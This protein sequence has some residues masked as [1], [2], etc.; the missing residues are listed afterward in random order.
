MTT[1][2]AGDVVQ[3]V[4]RDHKHFILQLTPGQQLHTHRGIFEHD[5]LIGRTL[6][7]EVFTHRGDPFFLLQP[8][9]DD[10]IREIKRNSQIIYP[11]DI[12]FILMKLSVRPGVTVVEAGTGSGGL[13]TVLAQAVG[14]TGRVISYEVREDMQNLARKNLERVG[15]ADRITFKLRDIAEGFDETDVYAL[16]LDVPNPWDYTGQ[17]YR[18]LQSGGF[19]GS[20]VP[21][22]NQVS[23]LLVSMR[24]EGFDFVEVCEVLLRYY[25]PVPDRLRPTDRMVA[26]T[27]FLIFGRPVIRSTPPPE[28]LD[29]QDET[30]DPDL[31]GGNSAE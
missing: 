28:T 6:G 7:T 30:D 31:A 21:T 18:A 17:A 22:A 14:P 24:R 4:G 13:T 12:G 16:F 15:L 5:A 3:L 11:K 27:G 25:K 8:S 26:H 9:T 29:A 1:A 23:E 2:Q 20:L 10:L 19:F